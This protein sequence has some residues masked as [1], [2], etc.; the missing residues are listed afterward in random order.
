MFLHCSFVSPLKT[1]YV[2]FRLFPL[3]IIKSPLVNCVSGAFPSERSRQ[4]SLQ[5]AMAHPADRTAAG[6]AADAERRSWKFRPPPAGLTATEFRQC[7]QHD[8]HGSCRLGAQCVE[9]HG[10]AE[11]EEWKV[12][13]NIRREHFVEQVENQVDQTLLERLRAEAAADVAANFAPQLPFAICCSK[14]P[15]F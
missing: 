3:T 15:R 13:W 4:C 10:W 6:S 12:R 14:T 1:I 2:F 5:Q 11:L 9:A 7:R 8:R